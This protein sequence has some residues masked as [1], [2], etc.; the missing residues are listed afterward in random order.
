[1]TLTLSPALGQIHDKRNHR[2]GDEQEEEDLGDTGG[3]GSDATKAKN[4]GNNG[5]YQKYKGK[6]KHKI[7]TCKRGWI[8]GV[9]GACFD[10]NGKGESH[11]NR[12]F[13]KNIYTNAPAPLLLLASKPI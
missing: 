2:D 12:K 7:E 9:L 8:A 11:E 13:V 10:G 6:T 3:A 5:Q 4:S 1:M